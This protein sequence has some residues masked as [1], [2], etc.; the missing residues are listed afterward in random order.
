ME[1]VELMSR[2]EREKEL[3]ASDMTRNEENAT[4]LKKKGMF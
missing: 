1:L 3:N 4:G 2:T